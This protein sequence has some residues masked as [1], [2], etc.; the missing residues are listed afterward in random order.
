VNGDSS[1]PQRILRNSVTRYEAV[2]AAVNAIEVT[3]LRE[4]TYP[5]R[6]ESNID[7]TC[8][9]EILREV[10]SMRIGLDRLEQ[11][12]VQP[13]TNESSIEDTGTDLIRSEVAAWRIRLD[14]LQQPIVQRETIATTTL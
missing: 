6:Y 13:E 1:S 10:A 14:C 5:N 12:I 3:T 9:A 4:R 11:L 7:D 8:I 2:A